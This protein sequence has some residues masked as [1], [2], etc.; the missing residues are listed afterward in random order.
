M[1]TKRW[2]KPIQFRLDCLKVISSRCLHN[3]LLLSLTLVC[4]VLVVIRN[5]TN[6]L[7]QTPERQSWFAHYVWPRK[8]RSHSHIVFWCLRVFNSSIEKC[9]IEVA[10]F[11]G[12]NTVIDQYRLK[13]IPVKWPAFRNFIQLWNPLIFQFTLSHKDIKMDPQDWETSQERNE[14]LGK[15][16]RGE[17]FHEIP[18]TSFPGPISLT[19]PFTYLFIFILSVTCDHWVSLLPDWILPE[20]LTSFEWENNSWV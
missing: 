5:K 8:R 12:K 17:N 15:S 7:S 3:H 18:I 2:R 4:L 16:R 6:Y 9:T 14:P 13:A 10:S 11:P 1:F 19:A 20:I